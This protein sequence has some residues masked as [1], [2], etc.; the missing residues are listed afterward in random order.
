MN[1]KKKRENKV[2]RGKYS[3]HISLLAPTF[4]TVYFA[5]SPLFTTM[6]LPS[7]LG[8]SEDNSK[9]YNMTSNFPFNSKTVRPRQIAL[10]INMVLFLF[11]MII[12]TPKVTNSNEFK[13]AVLLLKTVLA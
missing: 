7:V 13:K 12:F 6:S 1:K 2:K 11:L 8:N 4:D 3:T 10:Y 5:G 9:R